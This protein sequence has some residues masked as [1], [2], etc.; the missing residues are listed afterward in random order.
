MQ[1]NQMY[2]NH[3]KNGEFYTKLQALNKCEGSVCV[4]DWESLE[5]TVRHAIG[6]YYRK[7]AIYW[8]TG[9]AGI[10]GSAMNEMFNPFHTE[11]LEDILQETYIRMYEKFNEGF[12]YAE[13]S[14]NVMRCLS[15]SMY[16]IFRKENPITPEISNMIA[17]Q[18]DKTDKSTVNGM[19]L[20]YE[21]F[22]IKEVKELKA[23]ISNQGKL[24]PK[25]HMQRSRAYKKI[26]K[27][28]LQERLDIS[29]YIGLVG[30]R[31]VH[32]DYKYCDRLTEQKG[33]N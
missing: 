1:L 3:H 10:G 32:Q 5:E 24:E 16:Y 15:N 30:I 12:Q 28:S 11:K 17:Y 25:Q 21:Y 8:A 20:T 26:A 4:N 18:E 2:F 13:F 23:I 31:Q 29:A 14:K 33:K 9:R 19:F 6:L 27:C 7:S 22:N